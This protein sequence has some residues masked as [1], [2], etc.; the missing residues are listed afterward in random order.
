VINPNPVNTTQPTIPGKEEEKSEPPVA[1][2][3]RPV[4]ATI[5]EAEIQ[6]K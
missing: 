2:E 4:E 5:I 1:P 6:Q 3:D